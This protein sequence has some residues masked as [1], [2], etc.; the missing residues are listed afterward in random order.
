MVRDVF[1]NI[2]GETAVL[3]EIYGQ[4]AGSQK[5]KAKDGVTPT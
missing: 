2:W 1:E 3:R 5:Y 4:C